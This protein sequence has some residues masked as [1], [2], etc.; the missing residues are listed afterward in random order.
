MHKDLKNKAIIISGG[1]G[2]LG[3][4]FCKSFAKAGSFVIILDKKKPKFSNKKMFFFNCDIT[5]EFEVRRISKII[6]KKF[7]KIQALINC[8]AID[9]N[10]KIK[11]NKKDLSLENFNLNIWERDVNVGLKGSLITTKIFGTIMSNQKQVEKLLIFL[12]TLAL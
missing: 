3:M 1:S 9:Y 8:A 5:N 12:L 7:K 2:F 4:Q 11:I 6:K 10:P